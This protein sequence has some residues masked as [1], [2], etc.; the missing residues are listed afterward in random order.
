M[1]PTDKFLKH[2]L[3][4]GITCLRTSHAERGK[5]IASQ[6]SVSDVRGEQSSVL[7]CSDDRT[8]KYAI[9]RN[10]ISR[11]QGHSSYCTVLTKVN[12]SISRENSF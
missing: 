4:L 12:F 2:R 11:A 5:V 1:H 6:E 9:Y 10:I 7:R 3:V 8:T